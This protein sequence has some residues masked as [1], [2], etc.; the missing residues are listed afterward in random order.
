[1]IGSAAFLFGQAISTVT[2]SL[3]AVLLAPLPYRGRYAVITTWT[4]FNLWW[5]GVCCGLRHEVHGREYIPST[6][7]VIL[8]KHESA[9][10]TLALQLLF[11]PQSWVLKRELLRIPFFGWGLALLR[12]IAIDRRAGRDA[13]RELIRQGRDRLREGTWVVVFPEGTRV[14]PGEHRAYQKGGAVLAKRARVAVVPVAHNAGDYWRRQSLLKHPGT[15]QLCIGPPIGP[16]GLDSD[17]INRRA[18]AWIEGT[19]A[20]IRAGG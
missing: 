7:G 10:E 3:L 17:E 13:V 12:P 11:Q 2:F 20:R 16:A 19:V 5:L 1:V 9:W 14:A 4:R 6:P 8:C 15:I 18:E